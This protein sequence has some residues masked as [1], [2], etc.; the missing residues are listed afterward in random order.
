MSS[1]MPKSSS[2]WHTGGA[3][4]VTLIAEAHGPLCGYCPD[5]RPPPSTQEGRMQPDPQRNA[6][7]L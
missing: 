4:Y 5:H 6:E 2:G 1:H 3:H 7:Y